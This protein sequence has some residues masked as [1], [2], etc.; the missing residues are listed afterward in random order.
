[1]KIAVF[2]TIPFSDLIKEGF[3]KLGHE[4]SNNN[5][6]LIFLEIINAVRNSEVINKSLADCL[7]LNFSFILT[8][9]YSKL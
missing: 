9:N 3:I 4:I 5:P 6:D 8:D 1:M 2:G 7:K